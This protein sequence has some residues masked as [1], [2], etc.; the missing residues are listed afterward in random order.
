MSDFDSKPAES[1]IR[2]LTFTRAESGGDV[3]YNYC[4]GASEI[5]VDSITYAPHPW[6]EFNFEAMTGDAT[7]WKATLTMKVAPPF[8]S[9]LRRI[10]TAAVRV[11]ICEVDLNDEI[12][13]PIW[14]GMVS[15]PKKNPNN[16]ADLVELTME[17]LLGPGNA[18]LGVSCTAKCSARFGDGVCQFALDPLKTTL[19]IS[20]ISGYNVTLPGL[21]AACPV[22]GDSVPWPRGWERGYLLINGAPVLIRSWTATDTCELARRLPAEL[23]GAEVIAI[24]GC[25][26]TPEDCVIRDNAQHFFGLGLK[27]PIRDPQTQTQ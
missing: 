18:A 23:V 16:Q 4:T 25:S 13:K 24:P 14:A 2:L 27:I 15:I 22:D 8:D 1:V 3:D 12:V 10:P 17:G 5:T 11:L 19:T 9:I 26:G 20:A 6:L 7:T 21:S